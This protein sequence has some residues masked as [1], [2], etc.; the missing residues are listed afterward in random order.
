MIDLRGKKGLFTSESG[1]RWEITSVVFVLEYPLGDYF[2]VSLF[3][4]VYTGNYKTFRAVGVGA[5]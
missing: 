1:V 5:R 4:L 3:S 2:A